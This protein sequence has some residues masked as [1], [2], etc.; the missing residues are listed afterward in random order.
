M[1][2]LPAGVTLY[3]GRDFTGI[4]QTFTQ[5][6]SFLGNEPIGNDTV[7][8]LRICGN[9]RVTLYRD[10]DWTGV[11]GEFTSEDLNLSD[12]PIN[13]PNPT[14]SSLRIVDASDACNSLPSGV[15]LYSEGNFGG[16]SQSFS[17]DVMYL[18]N[19]SFGDNA[20][21]SIRVCGHWTVTLFR[22]ADWNGVWENFYGSRFQSIR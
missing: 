14:V 6:A 1:C 4:S 17:S 16:R 7:N 15:T 2:N 22:D 18:G 8:A 5:D 11:S 21:R 13:N 20:A 12:N 19:T 10:P 9:Y 3:H